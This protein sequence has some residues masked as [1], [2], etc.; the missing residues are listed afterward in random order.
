MPWLDIQINIFYSKRTTNRILTNL[1]SSHDD[2]VWE[3]KRRAEIV[4]AAPTKKKRAALA[5]TDDSGGISVHSD[6]VGKVVIYG[7]K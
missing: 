2:F 3:S 7:I 5:R 1:A 4:L 6:N